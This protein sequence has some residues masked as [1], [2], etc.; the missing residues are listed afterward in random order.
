MWD[1]AIIILRVLALPAGL[2]LLYSLFLYEEQ[3]RELDKKVQNCLSEWWVKIDDARDYSLSVHT[4]FM[5][6]VASLTDSGF[7]RLFGN[8][9]IS[10]Q[11]LGVSV[12]YSI[13]SIFLALLL[14]AG[15][16]AQSPDLPLVSRLLIIA[17]SLG[18]ALF[19]VSVGTLPAFT[20]RTAWL[21]IWG[22]LLAVGVVMI[23]SGVFLGYSTIVNDPN[24]NRWDPKLVFGV[25]VTS[26]GSICVALIIHV[27]TDAIFIAITRK[28][29]RWSSGL[30]SFTKITGLI[31]F[32]LILAFM[33]IKAPLLLQ[34]W[35]NEALIDW[36]SVIT[37]EWGV[38][39]D[40]AT[41]IDYAIFII[42]KI[43][44]ASNLVTAL[45]SFV[46]I[47]LGGVM[48]LH[49]LFWPLLDRPIYALEKLG[50]IRRKKLAFTLGIALIGVAVGGKVPSLL[51]DV[52][53]GFT[54]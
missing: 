32:N 10:L 54:G 17:I 43:F 42:I 22:A 38:T 2:L 35:I 3:E 18:L 23:L 25:M 27:M 51:K 14:E 49:R 6:Q 40:M 33:L 7:N 48:L 8:R 36:E 46:F 44:A 28:L 24:L 45:F 37:P 50:F 13:A 15:L 29:L 1:V 4:A 41:L 53:G 26:Y 31:V 16:T 5:R 21:V 9:I 39:R 30:H 11:S 20:P 12:W 19:F 52:I 34:D 47:V